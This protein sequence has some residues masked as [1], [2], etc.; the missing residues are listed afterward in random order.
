MQGG[1]GH[2]NTYI[3]LNVAIIV[4]GS[5]S[6]ST[7]TSTCTSAAAEKSSAREVAGVSA[8]ACPSTLSAASRCGLCRPTCSPGSGTGTGARER[9]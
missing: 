1:A 8:I 3:D 2:V 7:G 5:T 4:V 9:P 6:T